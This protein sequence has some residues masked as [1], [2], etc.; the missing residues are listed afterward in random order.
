M[1]LLNG[2]CLELMKSLPDNSIDLVIT[3]PPYFIDG[4][5]SNWNVSDLEN[6]E[7]KSKVIGGLPVGMKFNP[8]QGRNLQEFIYKVSIELMKV[9]KSGG[10]ALFF[11]QG[12]LHHRMAVAIE[13]SG[14]EIRD[15]YI[16]EHQGGM[17]KAFTQNHFINKKK[18]LTNLEKI[19]AIKIL[20]NR[21]TPQLLPKFESIV[22]AQKPKEGTFT[23]NFLKYK[24][25]LIKT[26][27]ENGSCY[28]T[29]FK[30]PKNTEKIDHLTVKPLGIIEELIDVFSMPNQKILDPFMGSGTT[31]V[32][33]VN[34]GREFIGIEKD[35]TYFELANKRIKLKEKN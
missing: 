35:P 18:N 27:K 6:K 5:G 23:D 30:C 31:G 20:D 24:V 32:A 33:C 9:L 34:T 12:R 15:M 11:S 4:M 2:D 10:Y 7:S 16:W 26:T 21:K 1:K 14:F 13:D 29:I 19:E 28:S 3:D 25:G 22:V 17:M 8:K